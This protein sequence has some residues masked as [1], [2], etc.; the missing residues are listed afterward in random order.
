MTPRE[1]SWFLPGPYDYGTV[2]RSSPPFSLRFG[3]RD[4]SGFA[5]RDFRFLFLDNVFLMGTGCISFQSCF[6]YVSYNRQ[7]LRPIHLLGSSLGVALVSQQ[8]LHKSP[9]SFPVM[10]RR[11]GGERK[12][13]AK[14][15]ARLAEGLAA[16]LAEEAAR[17]EPEF[18]RELEAAR[19]ESRTDRRRGSGPACRGRLYR[20]RTTCGRGSGSARSRIP[21]SNG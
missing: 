17:H 10:R 13:A 6:R 19:H 11:M 2:L 1:I 20:V 8:H 21:P 15:K 3:P 7:Q 5:P 12:G 9:P 18:L 16:R 4:W 14:A